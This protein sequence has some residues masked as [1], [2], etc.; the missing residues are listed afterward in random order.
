M[1][2]GVIV[3]EG[4]GVEGVRD[5]TNGIDELAEGSTIPEQKE[6]YL[7]IWQFTESL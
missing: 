2:S 3:F 4:L 1:D 7:W 6:C 5:H